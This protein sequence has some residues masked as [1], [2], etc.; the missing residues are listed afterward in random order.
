MGYSRPTSVLRSPVGLSYAVVALLSFVIVADLFSVFASVNLRG[1]VGPLPGDRFEVF[2]DEDLERADVLIATAG[3]LQSVGL[4]AAAVLFIIWFHRVR[5][6]AGVFA[7]DLQR[8]GP[9]WA[10]GGWFIPIGNLWIPRGVAGDIWVASRQDPYGRSKGESQAVLNAW[11]T[12]W[13]SSLL[14]D[15][16]ADR[17]YDD[18]KTAEALRTAANA[19]IVTDL[20]D[21]V[22]ALLAILVVRRLTRMQSVKAVRG[23]QEVAV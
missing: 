18:A 15:R 8:R 11:W 17:Q 5:I 1:V 23:P 2:A 10:I 3:G 13:I 4:L 22:A 14:I 20:V 21:I 9:G 7:P 19:F 12:A 16:V 6:N